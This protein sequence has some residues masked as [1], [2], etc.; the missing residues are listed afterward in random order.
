MPS[1]APNPLPR[2]PRDLASRVFSL[3]IGSDPERAYDQ[4][5]VQTKDQIIRMLPE[6]WSFEG[7][8]VMDF[9]SGAG[10]TLRHFHEEARSAEFWGVDLHGPSVE[11]MLENICPPFKAWQSA[12]VPP[13]AL[14][15]GTFDLI[16]TVSVFTHL[17]DESLPW[18]LELH[19]LLKPGGILVNSYMGRWNSEWFAQETW[20]ENR[21]GMNVLYR[22]RGWE[23]GG[24]ATLIS[25]WW[26]REHWG[27]A[28]EVVE[29]DPQFHN[30]SWVT[31]RKKDVDLTTDELERPGDDPREFASLRHNIRQL[32]REEVREL[33]HAADLHGRALR[34]QAHGYEE[35]IHHLEERLAGLEGSRAVRA[36]RLL[37]RLTGTE[38]KRLDP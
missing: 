21:V 26:L 35:R 12:A 10:R 6:E 38:R 14:E 18:L 28:F 17:T 25:D 5:G 15:Y 11:W 8:R 29:I 13:V 33:E 7:K 16:Y 1:P 34:E 9:G 19:R 22:H 2:P 31:L 20:D 32:Q 36:A 23:E 27:R 37:R 30:Y 4:L 3:P 24:P